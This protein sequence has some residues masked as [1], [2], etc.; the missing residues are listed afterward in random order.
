MGSLLITIASL[1]LRFSV[2]NFKNRSTFCEVI[3][4]NMGYTH[5]LYCTTVSDITFVINI[6]EIVSLVSSSFVKVSLFIR[7]FY[8][9]SKY[10]KSLHLY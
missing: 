5:S 10:T 6:F 7:L 2:N 3:G 9:V 1:L 8:G 4:K